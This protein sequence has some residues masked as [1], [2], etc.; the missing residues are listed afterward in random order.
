MNICHK[1]RVPVHT[2]N[3]INEYVNMKQINAY[4]ENNIVPFIK[5]FFTSVREKTT[6]MEPPSK[7]KLHTF[8]LN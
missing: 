1:N 4:M 6:F 8:T 3:H 5:N 2:C 7:T